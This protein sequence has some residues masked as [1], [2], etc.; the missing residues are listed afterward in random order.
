MSYS[1]CSNKYASQ[2]YSVQSKMYEVQNW[3]N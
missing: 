2:H 3:L 1:V